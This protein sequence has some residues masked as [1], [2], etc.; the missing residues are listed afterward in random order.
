MQ[1]NPILEKLVSLLGRS[2]NDLE[3][4]AVLTE[5]GIKLPLKRPKSYLTYNLLENEN[6]GFHIGFEYVSDIPLDFLQ[7]PLYTKIPQ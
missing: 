2:E 5:L 4:I 6:W 3:V 7:N 1:T